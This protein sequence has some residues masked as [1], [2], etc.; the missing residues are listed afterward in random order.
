[1]LYATCYMLCVITYMY[2]YIYT[3]IYIERDIYIYRERERYI[4]RARCE[5]PPDA[6]RRHLGSTPRRRTPAI[7]HTYR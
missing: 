3:Y 1:M 6:G 2:I 7:I 4:L 5:R